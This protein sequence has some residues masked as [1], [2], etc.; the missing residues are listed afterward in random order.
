MRVIAGSAK[1]RT[2]RAPPGRGT[3]PTADR[4][5]EALFASLGPSLRDAVVLDLWS[6]SGALAIEALSR[7]A[8][9]AVLVERDRAA[10]SVLRANLA[11]CGFTERAAVVAGDVRRFARRP[12]D[13][14][15]DLVLADPPYSAPAEEV[16]AVV[17]DLHGAGAL[18][19][20]AEVVVERGAKDP[21]PT[22]PSYLALDR[23]QP[24][25]DTALWRLTLADA[26]APADDDPGGP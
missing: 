4:V 19:A 26:P 10:V 7:G 5:R 3:R 23:V 9:R 21:V 16:W 11:A 6:G 22:P 20:G 8:Q 12:R 18:A 14:P 17:A 25:G 2:L 24:Y 15:F 1:G 13:G